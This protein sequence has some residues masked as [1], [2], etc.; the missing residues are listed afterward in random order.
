MKISPKCQTWV[1]VA[2]KQSALSMVCK[3]CRNNIPCVFEKHILDFCV[4]KRRV[5]I[6]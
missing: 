4:Y 5:T 1:K 2:N 3:P 6:P